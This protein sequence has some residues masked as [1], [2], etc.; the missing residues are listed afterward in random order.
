MGK[1]KVL[2]KAAELGI[3]VNQYSDPVT[4]EWN[5]D[6]HCEPGLVFSAHGLTTLAVW[7]S[8]DSPNWDYI[9]NELIGGDAEPCE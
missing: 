7:H 1:G 6:L 2:E 9:Y 8:F 3:M 4:K 5:V